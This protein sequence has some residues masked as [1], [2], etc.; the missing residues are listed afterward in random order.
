MA[1]E[2]LTSQADQLTYTGYAEHV[3]LRG[4]S[5]QILKI[6]WQARTRVQWAPEDR[7]VTPLEIRAQIVSWQEDI[8]APPPYGPPGMPIVRMRLGYGHAQQT[9]YEPLFAS[10]N[11]TYEGAPPA[12]PA[13]PPPTYA[14]VPALG[15]PIPARGFLGRITA[16]ELAIDLAYA[17]N[18]DTRAF[19]TVMVSIQPVESM[20]LPLV[21]S[22]ENIQQ[23]PAGT[24]TTAQ[25]AVFPPWAREWKIYDRVGRPFPS[26]MFYA[27]LID[28]EGQP[29]SNILA[30]DGPI[31]P[32][33]FDVATFADWTPISNESWAW[34]SVGP[35]GNDLFASYR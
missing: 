8:A 3:K 16:R 33:P 29:F 32:E 30:P 20:N 28:L 10:A 21:G 4:P 25:A 26:T 31:E 7:R 23:V 13:P 19:V 6:P 1:L 11:I 18:N 5:S 17:S 2:S 27:Y 35:Y 9:L 15:I 24:L 14:Q 34:Q 12:P 22:S